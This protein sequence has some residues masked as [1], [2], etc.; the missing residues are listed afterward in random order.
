MTP[1]QAAYERYL[2]GS[3]IIRPWSNC[4]ASTKLRWEEI[5]KA[6]IY[7]AE[8]NGEIQVIPYA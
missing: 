1:G 4:A 6:A 2:L 3:G 8:A 7:Q 5:A